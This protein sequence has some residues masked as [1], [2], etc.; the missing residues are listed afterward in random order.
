MPVNEHV[1]FWLSVHVAVA[2]EPTSRQVMEPRDRGR[3]AAR[4][5]S[6]IIIISF[7]HREVKNEIER[8]GTEKR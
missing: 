8:I 5:T 2:V 7:E 3:I 6:F 1:W 4:I